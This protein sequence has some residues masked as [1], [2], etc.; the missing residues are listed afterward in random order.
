MHSLA[1]L[2]ERVRRGEDLS[3][4]DLRNANLAGAKLMG[5]KLARSELDGALSDGVRGTLSKD[6]DFTKAPPVACRIDSVTD[7]RLRGRPRAGEKE[8]ASA[9]L[10]RFPI[11]GCDRTRSVLVASGSPL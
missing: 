7:E 6:G 4:F 11:E 10:A 3:R 9:F 8:S 1:G 2:E 5:A